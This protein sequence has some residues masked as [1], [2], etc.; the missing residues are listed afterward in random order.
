LIFVRSGT[1]HRKAVPQMSQV[2]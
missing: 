2:Q 1:S